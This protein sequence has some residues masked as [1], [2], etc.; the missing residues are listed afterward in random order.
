MTKINFKENK[1]MKSTSVFYEKRS[2]KSRF[3]SIL[4]DKGSWYNDSIMMMWMLATR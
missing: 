1:N 2:S 4:Y 3:N